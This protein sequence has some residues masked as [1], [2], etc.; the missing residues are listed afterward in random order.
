MKDELLKV[1][2]EIFFFFD[3]HENLKTKMIF[4]S[5]LFLDFG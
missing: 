1:Q 4:Y 2:G 5:S 3:F